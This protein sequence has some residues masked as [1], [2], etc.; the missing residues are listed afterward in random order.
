MARWIELDNL[1]LNT[2]MWIM[3][4]DMIK[5]DQRE[6]PWPNRWWPWGMWISTDRPKFNQEFMIRIRR[7]C[8]RSLVGDVVVRFVSKTAYN[9]HVV[10]YLDNQDDADAFVEEYGHLLVNMEEPGEVAVW[11]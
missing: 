7:F 10:F 2:S 1:D 4:E 6:P 3:F 9:D 11:M 5:F 8:D